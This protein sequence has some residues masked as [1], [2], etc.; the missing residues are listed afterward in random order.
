MFADFLAKAV[1]AGR[2]APII[3]QERQ[4]RVHHLRGDPGGG[5]VIKV[6]CLALA[7]TCRAVSLTKDSKTASLS[8]PSAAVSRTQIDANQLAGGTGKEEAVA[9]GGISPNQVWEYLRPGF[10]FETFGR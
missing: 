6:I 7:H 8:E 3:A 10:G 4:H 5:V 2:V 1:G 9:N